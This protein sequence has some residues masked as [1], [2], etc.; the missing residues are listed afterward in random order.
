MNENAVDQYGNSCLSLAAGSGNSDI[1]CMLLK[2]RGILVNQA[3]K[4]NSTPL[5]QA[6]FNG[7]GECV[8]SLLR[9][10]RVDINAKIMFDSSE[11]S[12]SINYGM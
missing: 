5:H 6:A 3:N 10:S 7:C 11:L 8:K 12:I 1:V 4:I 2:R 9:D